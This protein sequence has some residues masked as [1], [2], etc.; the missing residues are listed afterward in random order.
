MSTLRMTPPSAGMEY[1]EWSEVDTT[2]MT[3]TT[4][5]MDTES[6]SGQRDLARTI[7]IISLWVMF[8]FGV[9]GN[10]MVMIW[11]HLNRRRKSRV[12]TI[13]LGIASADMSVCFFSILPTALIVMSPTWEAGN[14][15]CKL[16][17][18]LQGASLISSANM[19]AL[20]AIDRHQAVLQ[21]LKEFFI[22]WKLVVISWGIAGILAL[23]QFYV[24]EE[25]IRRGKPRC[26]SLF[27]TLP[28]WHRMAYI[29][30]IAVITFLIP[31]LVI[32]FAYLRISKKIWDKAHET[33]GKRSKRASKK[34]KIELNRNASGTTL[35][36]AKSKTLKMSVVIIFFFVLCGAPYFVVEML[37]TFRS[38][39]I[40]GVVN[41]FF[42]LFAVANSATNPYIFLYFNTSQRCWKEFRLTVN[43][44]LCCCARG[45]NEGGYYNRYSVRFSSSNSRTEFTKI[46]GESSMITRVTEAPSTRVIPVSKDRDGH[47]GLG[48]TE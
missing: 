48:R 3:N 30:Y 10:T 20:M 27:R 16:V 42:G 24:W 21:P 15:M 38:N 32:T 4:I 41:A 6:T 45:N 37:A 44:F 8:G 23:P 40:N 1:T 36:K 18:Y 33:S 17:M 28:A 22:A 7:Q 43:R 14:F 13:V 19:L 2:A 26:G 35:T 5:N 29:V 9:L 11:M 39:P 25:M 46:H 31:F 34:N 47:G 12:N